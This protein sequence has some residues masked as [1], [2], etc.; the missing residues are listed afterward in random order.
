MDLHGI[1]KR[2]A[3]ELISGASSGFPIDAD[4]FNA[5]RKRDLNIV[6]MQSTGKWKAM[7]AVIDV[8]MLFVNANNSTHELLATLIVVCEY[9][10]PHPW[11]H[12]N[13]KRIFKNEYCFWP[14]LCNCM[15]L[16]AG[17]FKPIFGSS[18]DVF[19]S[20]SSVISL[21]LMM[22]RKSV[23]KFMHKIPCKYTVLSIKKSTF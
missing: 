19:M 9:H 23:W 5:G 15:E 13:N 7:R 14:V 1:E 3:S 10:L 11:N 17:I 4:L 2:S 22:S 18:A 16:Y 20:Y 12:D 21:H 6:S 8:P